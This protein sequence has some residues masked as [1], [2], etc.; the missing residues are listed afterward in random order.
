MLRIILGTVVYAAI[1]GFTVGA[2]L[3]SV[4]RL[5][6]LGLNTIVISAAVFVVAILATMARSL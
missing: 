4:T 6:E 3:H 1:L 2:V 5:K